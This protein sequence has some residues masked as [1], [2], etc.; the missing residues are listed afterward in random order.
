VGDCLQQHPSQKSIMNRLEFVQ[1][2]PRMLWHEEQ[3]DRP[4]HKV[5]ATEAAVAIARAA[6]TAA[7]AVAE[8]YEYC[9]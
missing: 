1:F 5:V 4:C 7:A 2:V 9:G 3:S 6:A 8:G